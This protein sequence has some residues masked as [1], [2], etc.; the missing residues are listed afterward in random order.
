MLFLSLTTISKTQ[1]YEHRIYSTISFTDLGCAG[2]VSSGSPMRLF[3]G[4][5]LLK[6][7]SGGELSSMSYSGCCQ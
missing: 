7:A 1:F 3:S 5:S 4:S 6:V 2:A